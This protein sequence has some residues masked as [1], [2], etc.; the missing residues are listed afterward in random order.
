M[1]DRHASGEPDPDHVAEEDVN[2][3]PP[4]QKALQEILETDK[5]DE[6]LQKYKAALLGSAAA[7][8]NIIVKPEDPRKVMVQNLQLI[9]DGRP[10]VTMNL[11]GKTLHGPQFRRLTQLGE[12]EVGGYGILLL[13]A[14]QV[15]PH[16]L[17]LLF[18]FVG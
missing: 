12:R 18:T 13:M 6:S 16:L 9:V 15:L 8:V 4:A 10:D 11:T 17:S 2:Y 7:S 14:N 1:V 3:K 5:E